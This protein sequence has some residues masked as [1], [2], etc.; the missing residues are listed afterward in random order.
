M[1]N[2]NWRY[3]FTFLF[4]FLFFFLLWEERTYEELWR[5]LNQ[6]KIPIA[7]LQQW[8]QKEEVVMH[9]SYP[10]LFTFFLWF[11]KIL[12]RVQCI[13]CIPS[14]FW[15][16]FFISLQMMTWRRRCATCTPFG[17][18]LFMASL[19]ITMRGGGECHVAWVPS[20]FFVSL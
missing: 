13:A 14:Y 20:Y 6:K 7:L 5:G 3:L 1:W 17:F 2:T 19:Q 15:G 4:C 10:F 11:L 12:N 8:Q 16:F 18:F 9:N